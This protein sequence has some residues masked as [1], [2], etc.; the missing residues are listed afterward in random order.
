MARKRKREKGGAY[1]VLLRK[2]EGK[3]PRGGS[4]RRWEDNFKVVHIVNFLVR[5]Y[6]ETKWSI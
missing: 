6:L 5:V 2:L 1:R 3:R 4:S